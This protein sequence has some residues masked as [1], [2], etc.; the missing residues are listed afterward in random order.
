MTK[1][2]VL[3]YDGS[4]WSLDPSPNISLIDSNDLDAIVSP[5]AG[6]VWAV[7]NQAQ[8]GLQLTLCPITVTNAGF[9]PAVVSVA[10]GGLITWLV[11][12]S[13]GEDHKV[14]D[15]TGMGLFSSGSLAPGSLFS[16]QF[17]WAGV[18]QARDGTTGNKGTVKVALAASPKTGKR[19]DPFT[20]T[21]ATQPPP[22]GYVEDIQI[23]RP[24]S[25]SWTDWMTGLAGTTATFTPDAGPGKYKFRAS[26][27]QTAN[28]ARTGW[29]STTITAT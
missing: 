10:E 29:S 17:S 7:G 19:T 20:V 22:P 16:F 12:D 2:L 23:K 25:H 9:A 21:Y 13:A 18:F 15:A 5:A 4:S 14:G 11:P 1:P 8:L 27:R 6:Q 26:M 3:H 28:G 24:G